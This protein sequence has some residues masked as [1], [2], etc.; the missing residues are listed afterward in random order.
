M[1]TLKGSELGC[2]SPLCAANFAENC[3]E[4]LVDRFVFWLFP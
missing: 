1:Q 3:I 4:Q 2:G